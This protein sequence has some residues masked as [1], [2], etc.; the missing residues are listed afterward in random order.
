MT[1]RSLWILNHY[2]SPPDRAAGTRHYDLGR[3]LTARGYRVTVFAA[4]FSHFTFKEERLRWWQLFR[5]EYFDGVRFI[6]LRTFPY[7]G[8]SALRL[9][10]MLSYAAAVLVVQARFSPPRWVIGS[11]VH[12]FAALAG[13]F[14]ARARRAVFLYEIRDLWPQT[15]VDMGAVPDRSPVARFMRMLERFLAERSAAVITLIGGLQNYFDE[16]GIRAT[17]VEYIPNGVMVAGTDSRPTFTSSPLGDWM[18]EG[19]FV[20][21]YVGVH[22]SANRLHVV[23][24]A[25]HVLEQ[26]GDDRIRIA[27]VGDGPE[28]QTLRQM[29]TELKL[30]NVVFLDPIPKE[31]VRPLLDHADAALF[32]LGETDVFRYGISSNK[33]FDYLGSGTPVVFACTS[34]YDPVAAAGAGISIRP[35]DPKALADAMQV[36]SSTATHELSAMG[37]RGR[38]YVVEHHSIESLGAQLDTLLQHVAR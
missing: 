12:P 19:R 23:I 8:N 28:K 31:G 13:Y 25:A 11:T 20:C 14:V 36:L 9:L 21:I 3:Q 37:D 6:W 35:D 10:N 5:S 29:A 4:G 16:R 2:A 34:G 24:E 26:R 1:V 17:R 32:H 27:L 30:Q 7:R 15:L 38:R 22:G 18:M 33:L